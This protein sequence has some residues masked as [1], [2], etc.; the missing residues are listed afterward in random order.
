MMRLAIFWWTE[1]VSW[2]VR[3]VDAVGWV[4]KDRFSFVAGVEPEGEYCGGQSSR[5][6]EVAVTEALDCNAF[7]S[8]SVK[9]TLSSSRSN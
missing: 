4:S 6:K 9:Y 8:P 1:R 7:L 5:E 3:L 2:S